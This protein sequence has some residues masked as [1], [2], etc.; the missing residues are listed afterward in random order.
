MDKILTFDC[1]GTLI[2]TEPISDTI[3]NIA[4]KNGLNSKEAVN[5]YVSYEDRLMYGEEYIPYDKLIK[6][7]LEYCDME[8]NSDVFSKAYYEIISVH[9]E[10]KPF[11]EVNETLKEIH[12]RGY[13]LVLMSNSVHDIMNYHLDALDN[14]FDD[15]FLA[16][17]IH[18]YKPQLEF[19]KYVEEKLKL[20][21]KKHCHIAK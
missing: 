18:A 17:D 15:V 9:K 1:Y 8:L 4:R 3:S 20:K 2:N 7:V 6:Q 19:F 11:D 14:V 12:K 13:K 10:L 21:E 5:I 16:E